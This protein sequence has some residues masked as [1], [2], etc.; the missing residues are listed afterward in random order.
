MYAQIEG[1]NVMLYGTI[2]E[3]DGKYIVSQISKLLS[4]AKTDVD[5]HLHTNGGSVF[6]GNL[7]YNAIAKAKAN[8]TI[9]IDGLAASMGSII[10]LSAHNLK[11]AE[12]A[13]I[14]V[15]APSGYQGG[16]AKDF[17]NTAK[18]LRSME[19]N[20]IKKLMAKTQL[21]EADVKD[22]MNGDNWF[23][24]DEAL[25]LGL[26]DEVV[27]PIIEESDLSA[28]QDVKLSAQLFGEFD[29]G[30]T[31]KPKPDN[32][33]NHKNRNEMKLSAESITALGLAPDASDAEINAAIAA[34]NKKVADLEAKA[35]NEFNAKCT[36][37][38]DAAVKSGKV[39]A[40]EKEAW[41]NDAKANF[42]LTSRMLEK[43]PTKKTLEANETAVTLVA[44]GTENRTFNEWR[45]VD[46]AGLLAIKKTDPERYA[47]I[48][49]KK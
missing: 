35:A 38:V 42:E 16:N 40:G 29:K 14:M 36:S 17:E 4:K 23:P 6:D 19:G 24:A 22:W 33:N 10:M 49:Q 11:I 3:G 47:A 48:Q 13:F 2:W 30:I 18:L 7:I 8:I 37:L 21:P 5:I 44:D 32:S 15:H 43:L 34:Q 25:D 28:Y 26:V 9:T 46:P 1:N 12:N 20:F 45:K 41:L 31:P 39:L 27:E